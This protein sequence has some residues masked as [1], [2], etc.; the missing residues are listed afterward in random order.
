MKPF[1]GYFAACHSFKY[2]A[3]HP[4][5]YHR[6]EKINKREKIKEPVNGR[7]DQQ[8]MKCVTK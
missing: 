1:V 8:A 4:V 6:R 3:D 7:K 5:L 2:F